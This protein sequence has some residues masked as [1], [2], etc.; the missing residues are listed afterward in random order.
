ATAPFRTTTA[1][2]APRSTSPTRPRTTMMGSTSMCA[3]T[4]MRM[5]HR[6]PSSMPHTHM[7]LD[8]VT[9]GTPS[10]LSS[11]PTRTRL[12]TAC[13]TGMRTSTPTIRTI[14]GARMPRAN[15]ARVRARAHRGWGRCS[16]CPRLGAFLLFRASSTRYVCDS[17]TG[18]CVCGLWFIGLCSPTPLEMEMLATCK[19]VRRIVFNSGAARLQLHVST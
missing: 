5:G 4:G 16:A 17:R 19:R 3:T 2:P 7:K 18:V 9:V 10:R 1:R 13:T 11:S 6:S 12:S 8:V 15:A 14:T